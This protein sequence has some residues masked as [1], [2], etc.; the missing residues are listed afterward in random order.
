M[1]DP[2]A[3]PCRN[4]RLTREYSK[5]VHGAFRPA[6]DIERKPWQEGM[7]IPYT[8]RCS[9]K[10]KCQLQWYYPSFWLTLGSKV[11]R[12]RR[13]GSVF[14]SALFL[15]VNSGS[16]ANLV[17]ISALT[18]TKLPKERRLDISDEVVTVAAGFPTTVAPW[19]K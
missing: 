1:S 18:S 19:F 9:L 12:W 14:G 13:I 3:K 15:L 8:G 7:V 6:T 2:Q 11:L 17:A 16:S 4:L 10:K 5:Q